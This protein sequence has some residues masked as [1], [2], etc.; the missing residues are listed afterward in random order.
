MIK[1]RAQEN[2]NFTFCHNLL[3]RYLYYLFP[4]VEFLALILF[5]NKC[6]P[7]AKQKHLVADQLIKHTTAV[8]CMNKG[9]GTKVVR[10]RV[11]FF[12][13]PSIWLKNIE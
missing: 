8:R 12:I 9:V 13:F 5:L 11:R 7:L 6:H 10:V 2:A 4:K 1:L 3:S